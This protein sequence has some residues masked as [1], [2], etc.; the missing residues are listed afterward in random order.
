MKKANTRF[1]EYVKSV[2]EKIENHILDYHHYYF[3]ASSI[4]LLVTSCI[5]LVAYIYI[6]GYSGPTFIQ[7]ELWFR[8]FDFAFFLS[9]FLGTC[10]RVYLD[11]L[12]KKK[13]VSLFEYIIASALLFN[14]LLVFFIDIELLNQIMV[15]M[16]F[17]LEVSKYA[18]DLPRLKIN[19]TFIFVI[20]FA[21]LIF[22]ASILLMLPNATHGDNLSFIDALFTA[23]SATTVT[24]LSVVNIG[25]EFTF[26]GQIIILIFIQIGG[27]G[28]MTFTS[29]LGLFFKGEGSFR[30]QLFVQNHTGAD[31]AN[32]AFSFVIK[33]IVFTLSIEGLGAM[34]IYLS[35]QDA[36]SKEFDH[37]YFSIFHS[38]SSFC[39]AGFS[40]LAEGLYDINIRFNYNLQLI[41]IWLVISGSL[42]FPIVFNLY[43]YLKYFVRKKIRSWVYKEKF[44]SQVWIINLNTRIVLY[45]T[46]ILLVLGTVVF[47]LLEHDGTLEEHHG[48]GAK[49]VS[50]FFASVMPR[51]IGLNTVDL[52]E[53]ALH[54]IL[55]IMLLMWIGGS[56]ASTAG[57]IKTS[58]IAIAIMNIFSVGTNKHRIDLRHRT[59]SEKSV[60]RA[61]A[62]ITLSFIFIGLSAFS[63]LY[64][65]KGKEPFPLIFEAFSAYCATGLS[66]GITSELS[67]GSKIV[68]IITMFLGRVGTMNLVIS[69]LRQ[70]NSVSYKYP[71]ENIFIN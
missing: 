44:I 26:F 55:F 5:A 40:T 27:L 56:P 47:Y 28:I 1:K 45:T 43:A 20:S 13:R 54:T 7:E 39:N 61:F 15:G 69:F 12:V 53:V 30:N 63:L 14:I 41:V 18:F 36:F 19:H 46:S 17:A 58:T 25:E 48:I 11:F 42:G 57:G 29:F 2:Y 6:L 66:L 4:Y 9:Y 3:K 35:T 49:F 22:I 64:F 67:D 62:I 16:L 31:K 52:G 60:H 65:E 59:V 10:L 21:I 37:V 71:D 50:S 70:I 68:L 32:E 8:T 51:S 33:T 34:L 38:I 24:G 23:A